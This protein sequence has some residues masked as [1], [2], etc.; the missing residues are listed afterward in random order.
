V[1]T[2][3]YDA[4]GN[5]LTAADY[6]GTYTSSYD[7]QNRLTEQTDPFGVALTYAYDAAGR[8]TTVQDSLGGTTTSVYDAANRLTTREFGGSSQTPLRIDLSY[9]NANRL[10]GLTRYS[11][12][13]GSSLV[14][15]TS[16]TYDAS[17][18]MTSIVSKDSTPATIS[19]YNYQYDNANRVTVQ[20]GTGATGT[21]SYDADNQVL[22]DGNTTYSYD[23]NGNRTMAG[24]TLGTDN[25]VTNDG[26]WAYTY[27]AT[28]NLTQKSN[29]SAT[30]NYGYDN[31]NHL[32]T[33]KETV[34]GSTSLQATYTYDVYG[35]RIQQQEWQSSTGT[36]T[37][38]SVWS[39]GQVVM[40]L[41]GSNAVQ[42]RYVS[43]NAVNQLFARIDGNGTAWWYLTD[44]VGSVRDVLNASGGSQDHTDYTAFGVIISQTSASA[45]GEFGWQGT[46]F[47]PLTGLQYHED[48]YYCP[49]AGTWTSQDPMGFGA[50]SGN[51]YGYAGNDPTNATDPT[52]LAD[53]KQPTEQLGPPEAEGEFYPSP[54][55]AGPVFGMGG[56][57]YP[58]SPY[59]PG[60]GLQ[61]YDPFGLSGNPDGTMS[62]GLFLRTP[63]PKAPK[64]LLIT[65]DNDPQIGLLAQLDLATNPFTG[66]YRG[67]RVKLF[68]PIDIQPDWETACK[69]FFKS[70]RACQ[71]IAFTHA[72]S[73][74]NL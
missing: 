43:G 10:T 29:S 45:Q 68:G 70:L 24:Y 41:N 49:A 61:P 7:A 37:T 23:S 51:L 34:S 28:G 62:G 74:H 67:A 16:Y 15:T 53:E 69:N 2:F 26:T 40:E 9:D 71:E 44:R 20:S 50:G 52:G 19:Y 46:S 60:G 55:S 27:D 5:Q 38:E 65:F 72:I 39:N 56:P 59:S 57:G 11:N 1:Q 17:S 48:R 66:A 12:L 8:Q 3:T 54:W 58:S 33:I 47:D 32:T 14:A 63:A 13:S 4:A 64:D 73:W 35:Q 30:W 22:S 36:V 21:Y 18:R 31:E 42:E 25:Q 6:N